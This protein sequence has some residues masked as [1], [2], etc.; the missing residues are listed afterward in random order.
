MRFDC[1]SPVHAVNALSRFVHKVFS[2][3]F[4][5][6][7]VVSA[8]RVKSFHQI[9]GIVV[10]CHESLCR[11]ARK[12]ALRVYYN[13]VW[14]KAR[15]AWRGILLLAARRITH[16]EGYGPGAAAVGI[17]VAERSATAVACEVTSLRG[18]TV[19]VHC[20]LRTAHSRT[21][22]LC[23]HLCVCC[24]CLCC[25]GCCRLRHT[26]ASPAGGFRVCRGR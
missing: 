1:R 12:G 14:A 17:H 23:C 13:H 6:F 11:C 5:L 7:S 26:N 20:A 19:H 10:I 21:Q 15:V 9:S 2:S 16:C 3:I 25:R 18:S 22:S 4:S 24:L 8:P